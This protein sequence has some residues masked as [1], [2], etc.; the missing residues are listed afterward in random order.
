[1]VPVEDGREGEGGEAVNQLQ[2][3]YMKISEVER[4]L[5]KP[6]LPRQRKKQLLERLLSYRHRLA[7]LRLHR[8]G[9]TNMAEEVF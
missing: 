7:V 1:M 9:L 4:E 3:L 6:G 8:Y 2:H 5:E